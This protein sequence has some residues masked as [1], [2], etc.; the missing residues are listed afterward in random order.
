MPQW[1]QYQNALLVESATV[2]SHSATASAAFTAAAGDV[3]V[4]NTAAT[5][6]TLALPLI[7][8]GGP[9][10]V[11]SIHATGTVIVSPNTADTNAL[12]NG[13]ASYT[14]TAATGTGAG[15]TTATFFSPDGVNWYS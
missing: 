14:L 12:V 10:K 2:L 9:V 5:G 6:N 13:G 11:I 4:F 3:H 15:A 7:A 8:T 1:P